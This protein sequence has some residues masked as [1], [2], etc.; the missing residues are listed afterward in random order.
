MKSFRFA[1]LRRRLHRWEATPALVWIT[2]AAWGVAAL[3]AAWCTWEFLRVA[4][5]RRTFPYGLEWMEGGMLMHALRVLQGVTLYPEPSPD[6]MPFLYGPGYSYAAAAVAKVSGPGLPALRLLSLLATIAVLLLIFR[7][8]FVSTRSAWIAAVSSGVFVGTFE[9]SGTWF[10]LARVDSLALALGLGALTLVQEDVRRSR[11]PWALMLAGVL[12]A[13]AVLTKQTMLVLLP[14]VAWG[15]LL[16]P[17]SAR[18][19]TSA[20][21]RSTE[22]AGSGAQGS[23]PRA[24]WYSILRRSELW[25]GGAELRELALFGGVFVA[26]LA[27]IALALQIQSDGWFFYYVLEL[28]S[29]HGMKGREYLLLSFWTNELPLRLPLATTAG[30]IL[31]CGFPLRLGLRRH[32]F[33]WLLCASCWAGSY[34]SRLHMGSFTNDLMPAHAALAIAFGVVLHAATRIPAAAARLSAGLLAIAQLLLLFPSGWERHVPGPHDYA[35]G[36]MVV[37]KIRSL[38]GDVLVVNHPHLAWLAGK[39][40]F[41]HH[42][43]MV[44]V[45]EADR[46]PRGVRELLEARWTPLFQQRA[47]SGVVLDSDWYMF[48]RPLRRAYRRTE[49]LQFQGRALIPKV[50]TPVRPSWVYTPKRKR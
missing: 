1:D 39:R 15:A 34:L 27:V 30:V 40:P 24:A 32:V 26:C 2:T 8:V 36:D 38:P 48:M 31:L 6:F 23:E 44:D 3:L 20:E 25:P 16:L 22:A 47:F 41:A 50:G 12:L 43:A 28:P 46:D 19:A 37:E 9:L 17:S 4:L 45:F 42:M 13:L 11:R 29:T 35:A 10:D 14:A 18:R 49:T 21:A 5:A 7:L 33:F